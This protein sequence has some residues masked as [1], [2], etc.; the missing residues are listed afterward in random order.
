M[1]S[2]LFERLLTTFAVVAAA[3]VAFMA[4]SVDF[5][6][7]SRYFFN[8]PTKWVIDF[9]EYALL[10]IL[11]LSTAWVLSKENHI[12][13][14]ILLTFCPLKVRR[15]LNV[16][17]S[18]IGAMAS[19]IFFWASTVVTWQTYKSSE[20]LWHSVIFP[21][22]PIWVVMPVG[23]LLLTVQ[24]LR[25]SWSFAKRSEVIKSRGH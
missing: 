14:D 4:V 13:V 16:I 25:R 15:V 19:G 3:S 23:S 5:E 1:L 9:T 7:V 22:W 10:Y 21:K 2:Q 8:H 18:L 11:F 24:F 12:T 6:V 20:V 17:A